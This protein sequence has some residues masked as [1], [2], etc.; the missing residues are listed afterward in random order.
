MKPFCPTEKEVNELME[1]LFETVG[2]SCSS[3]NHSR[4]WL[5]VAMVIRLPSFQLKEDLAGQEVEDEG[6]EEE[7]E[8][9][10]AEARLAEEEEEEE[11][12]Y[13]NRHVHVSTAEAAG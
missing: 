8:S 5:P 1:E 12:R 2:S 6:H 7:E 10:N 3:A 11:D 4:M 13:V 9:H